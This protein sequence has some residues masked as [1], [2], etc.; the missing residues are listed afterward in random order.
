MAKALRVA[1]EGGDKLRRTARALREAGRVDLVRDVPKAVKAEAKPTLD[2]LKAAARHARVTGVR[3]TSPHRF[4]HHT[5]AK[6]LRE[7]MAAATI[8]EVRTTERDTR[9]AFHVKSDHMGD[10]KQIPRYIDL[11]NRVR[12]RHPVM[13]N[14]ER[15]AQSKGQPW[16][17]EPIKKHLPKMRERISAVL[18]EILAKVERS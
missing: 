6:H 17:F 8:V 11:G 16:F 9:I 5:R 3:T 4:E 14:R 10:A 15:W 1:I 13:G 2:D 12:W 7:R 18:D